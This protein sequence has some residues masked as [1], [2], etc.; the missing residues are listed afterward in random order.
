MLS[1]QD[2]ANFIWQVADDILRGAFKA[3]E[4]GD[5]T[6]PFVVLRR[7]DSVLRAKKDAVIST[8]KSFKDVLEA[9]QLEQVVLQTTGGLNFYNVSDFDLERLTQDAGNIEIN[10]NAYLNGF[11][12]TSGRSSNTTGSTA[13]RRSS[14]R[15]TCSS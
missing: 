1:F 6:L 4:Y 10:F 2:R 3:H 12:A 13:S 15:T 11:S 7:L 14:R 9:H 5:V 8:Y